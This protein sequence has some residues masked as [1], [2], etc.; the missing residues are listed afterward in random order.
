MPSVILFKALKS[1]IRRQRGG[2]EV[3][4]LFIIHV[5]ELYVLIDSF[6]HF[7]AKGRRFLTEIVL[8]LSAVV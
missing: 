4:F 2:P 6:K 8:L 3:A 5:G 7:F 1:V